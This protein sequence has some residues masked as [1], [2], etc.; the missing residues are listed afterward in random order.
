MF[1]KKSLIIGC[2]FVSGPI[3]LAKNAYDS[4]NTF[5]Q[6]EKPTRNPYMQR[7]QGID[8]QEPASKVISPLDHKQLMGQCP[9]AIVAIVENQ[10]LT[11]DDVQKKLVPFLR[12]IRRE[13]SSES[14]FNEKIEKI[15]KEILDN[16]INEILL[17]NEFKANKKLKIPESAM[18]NQFAKFMQEQFQGDRTKFVEFLKAQNKTERQFREEQKNQI[19]LSFS[20]MHLQKSLSEISPER[21]QKYYRE[22]EDQFKM[23]QAIHMRQIILSPLANDPDGSLLKEKEEEVIRHLDNN[24]QFDEVAKEFSTDEM[25]KTGGDWGWINRED[26]RKELA[27]A[28]FALK[29]G[30]YSKPIKLDNYVFI[31]YVEDKREEGILAL[32]KVRDQIEKLIANDEVKKLQEKHIEKL[33]KKALIKYYV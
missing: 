9:N 20:R 24:R 22:H 2:L 29:K 5:F 3:L 27:D 31:L 14:E 10:A 23:T 30:E 16:M 1:N 15:G 4:Y 25:R 33:R 6:E 8:N 11:I 26:I 17:V 7:E 13:I 32:E 19:I 21:I 12:Q 28:A 18:E